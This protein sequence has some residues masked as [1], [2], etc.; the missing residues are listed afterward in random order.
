LICQ[1]IAE[2]LGLDGK[3]VSISIMKV[4]SEEEE[5]TTKM[6]KVQVNPLD[7]K[8]TF[9]VK[10]IGIPCVSNNV[11]DI[12]TKDITWKLGLKNELFY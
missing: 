4:G 5:M 12:R 6:F 10:A 3:K 2:A 1:D 8:K 9:L 7:S 11:V